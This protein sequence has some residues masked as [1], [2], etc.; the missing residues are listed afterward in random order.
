MSITPTSP[1][2]AAPPAQRIQP[3]AAATTT[4]AGLVFGGNVAGT[5]LGFA[6][7]VLIMRAL[8]AE[9]FGV[10]I[11]TTTVLSVLWQI[12]GRGLDQA[13]VRCLALYR[14]SDPDKAADAA[15]TAHQAKWILGVAVALA[16]VTLAGP[17]TRF[18]IGPQ[19]SAVPMMVAA[20]SSLAA[21]LWG[22][23]GAC[24][25]AT[26]RL[27]GYSLVLVSNAAVR[28]ALVGLLI[29]AGAMTIT[30]AMASLGLAYLAAAVLGYWLCPTETHGLAGRAEMRPLL[31]S[32]SIWL[33][34]SSVI[35]LLYSR[36][37]QLMLSRIVGSQP[38]GVYGAAAS[39]VQLV[40]LLT[41]SLLT[42]MLPRA[43]RETQAGPL[44]RHAVHSLRSSA[45]FAVPMLAGFVLADPVI[46]RLLGPSY[47]QTALLF[48]IMLAGALLNV[49]THPLQ[50]VMH[51]RGRTGRLLVLDIALLAVGAVSTLWAVR[52]YGTIGAAAT[53]TGL[54]VA[55]G[56]ALVAL[57]FSELR[58]PDAGPASSACASETP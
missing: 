58:K 42:V 29:F 38:T 27:G 51:A 49:L 41:A 31:F 28:L 4:A 10:V 21:S 16:G 32:W 11:V 40:D 45:V 30:T 6:A 37:D 14:G 55:A 13:V 22:Y 34:I 15:R 1:R 33:V 50:A 2:L 26:G 19:A 53:S 35:H 18:F 46:G 44:R 52:H 17:L 43:C 57:V 54:R 5:A 25:Q 36:M 39:F 23:T 3:R 8:G 20:G 12:T 47:A 48:K 24:L 7:N 56:F 9:G